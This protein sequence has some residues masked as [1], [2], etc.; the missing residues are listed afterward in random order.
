MSKEDPRNVL[1]LCTTQ[2]RGQPNFEIRFVRCDVVST[3]FSPVFHNKYSPLLSPPPR[4]SPPRAQG[5]AVQQDGP[6]AQKL[7]HHAVD[8]EGRAHAYYLEAEQSTHKV[9]GAQVET[10]CAAAAPSLPSP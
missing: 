6:G 4:R 8:P 5:T 7:Y 2:A 10:K 9:G 3:V 1:L